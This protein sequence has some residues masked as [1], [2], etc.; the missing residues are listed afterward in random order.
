MDRTKA[1]ILISALVLSFL[2]LELVRRRRLREEYSWLWLLTAIVY[3]LVAM[4]PKLSVWI[5]QLI[6]T[7]SPP[8]ALTFIGLLFVILILIQFS[9][10]LSRLTNQMKELTQEIAILDSDQ[11]KS[12]EPVPDEM[13]QEN[14]QR[15]PVIELEQ[16]W[17]SP[18]NQQV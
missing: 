14:P 12:I 1:I 16:D 10:R 4:Y 5:A 6:G 15:E 13:V 11:N 9:V 8:V 18:A 7:N 2:V 17:V 3:L